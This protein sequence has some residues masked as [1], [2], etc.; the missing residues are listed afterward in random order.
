LYKRSHSE[1]DGI[2]LHAPRKID[3]LS[4]PTGCWDDVIKLMVRM[5]FE[6]ESVQFNTVMGLKEKLRT[7]RY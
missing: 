6:S 4:S 3:E 5:R 1:V 7:Y 2:V